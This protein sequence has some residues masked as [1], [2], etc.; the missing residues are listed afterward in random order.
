MRKLFF[1][2]LLLV[3]INVCCAQDVPEISASFISTQ[4]SG[5]Y[6]LGS[7]ALLNMAFS[8]VLSAR[9]SGHTKYFHQMNGYWN[10][11]NAGLAGFG[12]LGLRGNGAEL[13]EYS[14]LLS[15]TLRMEKILL[16]NA[17]LDIG[18][19]MTGFFLR[20][21]S[22]NVEKNKDRFLGF[23][24]SLIL[25]G[26]FLFLFDLGFYYFI[27]Q[28]ELDLIRLTENLQFSLNSYGATIRLRL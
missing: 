28:H 8:P 9:T 1:L 18:Y 10:L 27:H 17:G 4:K 13:L 24:N 6:V 7:W 14:D 5:M 3:V 26:S 21:R 19:I 11:V 15:E 2:I 20:E 22:K 25:Q 12:L 16:F 23:G